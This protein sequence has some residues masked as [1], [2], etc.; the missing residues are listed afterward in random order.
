VLGDYIR[1]KMLFSFDHPERSRIFS[2]EIMRGAPLLRPLIE[3]STRRTEQAAA[4]LR[5]WIDDGLMAPLDPLL[6][7]F[8]VWALTQH[9][10]DYQHQVRWFRGRCGEDPSDRERLIGEVTAFVLRGA[11]VDR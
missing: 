5:Q 7:L 3:N 9:Y 4:V 11:G 8:H 1:R 2:A 6:L 10:A